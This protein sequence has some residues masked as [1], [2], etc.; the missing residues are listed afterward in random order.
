[1]DH[2]LSS[3]LFPLGQVLV[4]KSYKAKPRKR[5]WKLKTLGATFE[6][7]LFLVVLRV[8]MCVCACLCCE[9]SSYSTKKNATN[10][11]LAHQQHSNS[12]PYP[13]LF[14]YRMTM[15]DLYLAQPQ[16]AARRK[17]L[18][19]IV[20][21]V[22]SWSE[23]RRS[24]RDSWQ[25]WSTIQSFVRELTSTEVRGRNQKKRNVGVRIHAKMYF[26]SSRWSWTV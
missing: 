23:S 7:R 8:C 12:S 6:V 24:L 11:L 3:S 4:T 20:N 16:P 13:P 15:A 18:A 17:S 14:F 21:E 9:I 22:T 10:E 1:M 2:Q 25:K 19:E 26:F 5:A